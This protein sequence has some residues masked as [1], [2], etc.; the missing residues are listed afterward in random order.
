[1]K[2]GRL[3]AN[4][5]GVKSGEAAQRMGLDVSVDSQSGFKTKVAFHVRD[6]FENRYLLFDAT[7]SELSVVPVEQSRVA[8][9][10][11][12]PR[13]NDLLFGVDCESHGCPPGVRAYFVSQSNDETEE[14]LFTDETLESGAAVA[15]AGRAIAT[16]FQASNGQSEAYLIVSGAAHRL[17]VIN[18]T[19]FFF[20]WDWSEVN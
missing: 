16:S 12:A 7:T 3:I 10:A 15:W 18:E 9:V 4:P 20:S 11:P 14:V 8:S 1:M 13:G 5:L 17:D 2:I 19:G 6:G